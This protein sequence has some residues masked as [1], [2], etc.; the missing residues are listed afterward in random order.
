MRHAALNPTGPRLVEAPVGVDRRKLIDATPTVVSNGPL[1]SGR[2]YLRCKCDRNRNIAW[3]IADPDHGP[4][5]A[6]PLPEHRSQKLGRAI[7]HGRVA[8]KNHPRTRCDQP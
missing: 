1:C 3:Q 4:D 5:M 2:E 6:C 8:E 7:Q